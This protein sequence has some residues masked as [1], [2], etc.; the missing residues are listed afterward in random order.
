MRIIGITGGIGT[1]KSTVSRY[2][3]DR[4]YDVV[5][6]DG[7]AKELASDPSVLAEIRDYFGDDVI[8]SDGIL[9]R[10]RMAS[11]VFSDF[12]KKEMLESIIT[13]RVIQK[14]AGIIEDYREGRLS[15]AKNDTVFLDAPTLFETG[16]DR[17]CDEIWLVT[18]SLETRLERAAKRDASTRE[19]LE[20]RIAAQMPES[21]KA[22][23]SDEVIYNDGS[24]E[25][26]SDKIDQLLSRLEI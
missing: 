10:K 8:T 15:P 19:D 5:D 18:C 26:L 11:L 14:T 20:A 7:I 25:E 24:K 9:D 3:R 23:R 17:I 4:G 2:L 12:G 16:A 6:A 13:S 21:E 1:G 22:A